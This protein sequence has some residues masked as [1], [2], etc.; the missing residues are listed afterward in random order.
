MPRER[1]VQTVKTTSGKVSRASLI[2]WWRLLQ[3]IGLIYCNGLGCTHKVFPGSR[4][5]EAVICCRM[6]GFKVHRPLRSCLFLFFVPRSFAV[7]RNIP[8]SYNFPKTI[9]EWETITGIGSTNPNSLNCVKRKKKFWCYEK[10][11]LPSSLCES[12]HYLWIA[13][14]NCD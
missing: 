9:L 11:N 12:F 6:E 7:D 14:G 1:I 10:I 8:T 2:R 3:I 5:A 13:K 4:A